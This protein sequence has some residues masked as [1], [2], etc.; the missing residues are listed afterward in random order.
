MRRASMVAIGARSF[1]SG[2]DTTLEAVER[3]SQSSTEPENDTTNAPSSG[4]DLGGQG[5][6]N[7][8]LD[9]CRS[10]AQRCNPYNWTSEAQYNV[11][12]KLK[13]L[14]S[15]C[16][17]VSGFGFVLDIRFPSPCHEVMDALA[18]FNLE[19][20]GFIPFGCIIESD[21]FLNLIFTTLVPIL[22]SVALFVGHKVYSA[23]VRDLS[24]VLAS[25]FLLV[26]FLVLPECSKKIFATFRC[27]EYE[28]VYDDGELE[29]ER[30]LAMGKG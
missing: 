6:K 7:G 17:L 22:F 30:L 29:A 12:N 16:Q 2:V 3:P 11:R 9:R 8:L 1:N 26:T 25:I 28:A 14:I 10:W 18:F 5:R 24:N 4:N 23:R 13:I 19:L 20:F 21:Y 27:N 15:F